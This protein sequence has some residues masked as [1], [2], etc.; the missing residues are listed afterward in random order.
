[1]VPLPRPE[2]HNHK[3]PANLSQAAQLP[4]QTGDCLDTS[5]QHSVQTRIVRLVPNWEESLVYLQVATACLCVPG[6]R[7]M[8]VCISEQTK[9]ELTVRTK[10]VACLR[11][12][13]ACGFDEASN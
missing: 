9:P 11:L 13:S 3:P 4:G 10:K 1:M 5:R 8:R 2:H 6:I 12:R 7:A